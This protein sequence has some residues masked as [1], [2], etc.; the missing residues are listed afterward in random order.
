MNTTTNT[1]S[2]SGKAEADLLFAA[3]FGPHSSRNPRSDEY[4]AGCYAVLSWRTGAV[5]TMPR[6]P[7]RLGSAQ[8]D[9]WFSGVDEGNAR[10]R[11][12]GSVGAERG[13]AA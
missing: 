12:A 6:C 4:K 2:Q 9:A 11:N 10:W 7:H 8:A 5:A 1:F 13:V 3:A